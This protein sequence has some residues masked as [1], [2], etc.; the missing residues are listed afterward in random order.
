MEDGRLAIRFLGSLSK[1]NRAHS[2]KFLSQ[3]HPL[4]DECSGFLSVGTW[5][6]LVEHSLGVR[7]VGSSNLPVP[8]ILHFSPA[9]TNESKGGIAAK[10]NREQDD[11]LLAQRQD[12]LHIPLFTR[13]GVVLR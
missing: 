6:S 13:L 1:R 9:A 5:L 3:P 4:S 8:T 10:P 11:F 7:G 2:V 12:L